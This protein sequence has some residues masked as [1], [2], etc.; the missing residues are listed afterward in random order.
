MNDEA[1]ELRSIMIIDD[2]LIDQKIHSKIIKHSNLFQIIINCYS[3]DEAIA[4]LRQEG[5]SSEHY[6]IPD[7]ILLDI[8]MPEKNGFEFLEEFNKF[9]NSQFS[10]IKIF[11]LSSTLDSSDITR[12]SAE[13]KVINFLTKPLEYDLF[14][15]SVH[16]A[17]KENKSTTK[18]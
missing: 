5:Q 6:V 10:N 3:T 1:R 8:E 17:W 7:I 9:N 18:L 15:A 11:I 14:V 2:S 4:Y 16:E 12:A 13:E